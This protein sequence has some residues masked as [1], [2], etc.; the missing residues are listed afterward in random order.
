MKGKRYP[1]LIT[2]AVFGAVFVGGIITAWVFTLKEIGTKGFNYIMPQDKMDIL[3]FQLFLFLTAI[4]ALSFIFNM[5]GLFNGNSRHILIAGILYIL[6]L[7]LISAPLCLTEY[8]GAKH[9]I[10]NKL[11][12]YTMIYTFIFTALLVALFVDVAIGSED[13]ASLPFLIYAISIIS[14][15]IILNFIGWKT[16][17]NKAKIAAGVA[18]ILG[19]FTVISAIICFV[20]GRDFFQAFKAIKNK[21]LFYALIFACVLGASSIAASQFLMVRRDGSRPLF[22]EFAVYLFFTTGIGL[23]LNFIAWKT[24]N[25]IAKILAGI[26]YIFGISTVISAILCFISCAKRRRTNGLPSAYFT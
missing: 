12:F 18:Y 8:F 5:L 16:G 4:I 19:I 1:L 17:N 14:A 15:G 26:A 21:L 20:S 24:G 9:N 6:G 23:I 11:L 22:N 25:V 2:S 3:T 13:Q 7:N 10:K